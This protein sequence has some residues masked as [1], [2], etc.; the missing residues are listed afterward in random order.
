MEMKREFAQSD[1]YLLP[2][3]EQN[4][5]NGWHNANAEKKLKRF[6]QN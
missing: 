5:Q 2:F 6:S 3:S 4:S 1:T